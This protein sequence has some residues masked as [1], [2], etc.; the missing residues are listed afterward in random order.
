MLDQ[1][2]KKNTKIRPEEARSSEI[3][4]EVWRIKD[5]NV[6]KKWSHTSSQSYLQLEEE[7][8][9]VKSLKFL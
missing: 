7:L 1:A 2:L 4:S 5:Q 9:K 3:T 6:W 8:S